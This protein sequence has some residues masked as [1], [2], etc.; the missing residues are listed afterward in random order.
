MTLMEHMISGNESTLTV[1]LVPLEICCF[2][3]SHG[4]IIDFPSSLQ[5]V[6][7]PTHR[8]RKEIP[9]QHHQSRLQSETTE[10]ERQSPGKRINLQVDG[11]G[12]QRLR[13]NQTDSVE[14]R[15]LDHAATMRL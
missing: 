13:A 10:Q 5:N 2:T 14:P 8:R 12:D 3:L 4:Y 7:D 1:L 6:V 11:V 15:I 9:G